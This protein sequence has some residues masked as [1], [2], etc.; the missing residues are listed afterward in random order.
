M[1]P[2]DPKREPIATVKFA[3]C[4]ERPVYHDGQGQYVLD[5]N[6]KPIYGV[7]FVPEGESDVPSIVGDGDELPF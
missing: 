2:T 3:D 6:G 5:G 4:V 7:W 1:N